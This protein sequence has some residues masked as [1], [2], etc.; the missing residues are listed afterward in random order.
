MNLRALTAADLPAI[1]AVHQV[2]FPCTVASRLGLEAS[3]RQYESLMTGPYG[4]AGLG[5][6]EQNRLVGF[7]FVGVRHASERDFVRHHAWFL[8]WRL[9]TRPWL[10]A[11]AVIFRRL[12]LAAKMFGACRLRLASKSTTA[13]GGFEPAIRSY[14]IHYLAVDPLYRGRGIGQSLV[15]AGETL[16]HQQGVAEIQLSVDTDNVPAIGLYLRMG[17]Q[18]S[19]PSGEWLGL[20]TKRLISP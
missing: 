5:A 12:G 14:G 15:V 13:A 1:A 10:L 8:I 4:T 9:S 20:M 7:C 19:A 6:F 17:W 2:A 11:D 18:K 3:R 16:A